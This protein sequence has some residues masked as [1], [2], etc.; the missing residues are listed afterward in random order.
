MKRLAQIV[1]NFW[2]PVS[3]SEWT[4]AHKYLSIII[5]GGFVVF[6]IWIPEN[7]LSLHPW[8]GGFTG[9]FESLIPQIDNVTRGNPYEDKFRV[10]FST[11]WAV[12]PLLIPLIIKEQLYLIQVEDKKR[13]DVDWSLH[14]I[15]IL[16]M[17]FFSVYIL[18]FLDFTPRRR[19][20][21][22]LLASLIG[23]PVAAPLLVYGVLYPVCYVISL[24]IAKKRY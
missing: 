8:L 16:F 4:R 22:T 13:K 11:I 17:S 1:Y 10:L 7:I 23:T 3:R 19:T 2:F 24:F 12:S 20:S 14:F 5:L 21:R 9:F 15:R 18:F 6:G